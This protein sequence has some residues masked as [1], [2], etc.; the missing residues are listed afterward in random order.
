MIFQ[1]VTF[2]WFKIYSACWKGQLDFKFS[3]HRETQN[4]FK[5]I[6]CIECGHT[7]VITRIGIHLHVHLHSKYS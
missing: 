5:Q 1:E 6:A 7:V 3:F 2:E 4:H